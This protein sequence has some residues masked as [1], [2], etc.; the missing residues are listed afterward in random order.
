M[1]LES[2]GHSHRLSGHGQTEPH[3]S[4]IRKLPYDLLIIDEAH[5]LK[6]SST[7]GY[8]FVNSIQK[9]YCLMLTA[10]PIQNDLKEL[11]NLIA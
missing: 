4:V 10:T 1:G 11:Y 7:I 6:N 5:K 8:R 9:K 2:L 3:A